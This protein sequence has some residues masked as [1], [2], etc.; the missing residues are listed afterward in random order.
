MVAMKSQAGL[1]EGRSGTSEAIDTKSL[2]L[3]QLC[4]PQLGHVSNIRGSRINLIPLRI[5]YTAATPNQPST[6][7]CLCEMRKSAF[8]L[9]LFEVRSKP[10]HS[11]HNSR[12]AIGI[13]RH[14]R[15]GS[16]KATASTIAD[17]EDDRILG[18]TIRIASPIPRRSKVTTTVSAST[19][20]LRKIWH[21]TRNG[22]VVNTCSGGFQHR[23]LPAVADGKAVKG[24]GAADKHSNAHI[25]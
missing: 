16:V 23:S 3:L 6:R 7:D 5:C 24:D 18:F 13:T 17:A 1:I 25:R 21:S 8:P 10:P 20:L 19:E 4:N 2:A 12:K 15:R 9:R 11:F 22:G 14:S